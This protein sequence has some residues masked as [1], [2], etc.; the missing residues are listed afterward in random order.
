MMKF[1]FY[2]C[3]PGILS[4]FICLALT[5]GADE[6]PKPGER[7]TKTVQGVEFAFR[8]CPPGTFWMGSPEDDEER[9]ENEVYHKVTLTQGF[10]MMENEVTQAQWK[11]VMG[12]NPSYFRGDELPVET[13]TWYECQKFCRKARRAGLPL[14]LPSE[15][16]W[17]YAC[18]AGAET[19]FSFGDT[20]A[21]MFRYANYADRSNTNEYPWRDPVHDDGF[22]KTAPVRSFQPNAWGLYDMHGNVSEWCADAFTTDFSDEETDPVY[23]RPSDNMASRGSSWFSLAGD[24]RITHRTA[25][26]PFFRNFGLGLRCVYEEK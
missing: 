25:L 18:R 12:E 23:E 9:W 4:L 8:W 24:S 16:Q 17:E 10:W 6:N 15:A 7:M 1:F 20:D 13:V 5:A 21:E 11:A 2:R 3:I 14:V 26:A 22:D 19:Q